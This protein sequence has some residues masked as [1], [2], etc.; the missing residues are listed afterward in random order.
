MPAA[1]E[2]KFKDVP[3]DHW[4]AKSVYNLV[5]LGIT[6]GYPDGTFRGSKNITRY[7]TAIFLSK[8][9]EKMGAGDASQIKQDLEAIK[10]DI[11]ALKK[12]G[13]P[14]A[15]YGSVE[16]NSMFTNILATKGVS[17]KGP[18]V[19]YR[20][21]TGIEKEL[22]ESASI[23]LNI[24]T[25]DAGFY[26]G[27]RDLAKDMIDWEGKLKLNPV[28]LGV[29]GDI[30]FAPVEVKFTAGPGIVQHFDL[31][32]IATSEDGICYLRPK[33]GVMVSSKLG[34]LSV[35]GSYLISN[36]DRDNSGKVN[37]N[38][39]ALTLGWAVRNL[40][41]ELNGGFYAKNPN[42]GGPRDSK[43]RINL[44]SEINQKVSANASLSISGSEKRSWL[45]EA[46]VSL[47]NFIEGANIMVKA[48]KIGSDFIPADLLVEELGETGF[49]VFMRPLE[50]STAN[51]DYEFSQIL[52]DKLAFK[53]KG[54]WRL[55]PDFGYGPDKQKSRQTIQAGFSYLPAQDI[56]IDAYY[57]TNQDPTIGETTDLSAIS[58]YY[59]F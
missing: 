58:I 21:K 29:L 35:S 1:A 22:N 44:S 12:T 51:I 42:S 47:S 8:L 59:R 32:G 7:E 33:T 2:V 9:A 50:N 30:L 53:S 52:T 31:T 15:V 57:R 23:K 46:G 55:T 26:G 16:M 40:M 56:N 6:N 14:P 43:I 49:D 37:T 5:K 11:A 4:A 38:Y 17:G 36:F 41:V 54:A 34:A 3:A 45:A 48:T 27:V 19:N 13:K 25:M 28:D 24:D 10:N 18:I 20:L 39:G